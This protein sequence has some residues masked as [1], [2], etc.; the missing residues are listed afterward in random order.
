MSVIQARRVTCSL[1]LAMFCAVIALAHSPQLIGFA[2]PAP[3][4]LQAQATAHAVAAE[5][6]GL[7]EVNLRQPGLSQFASAVDQAHLVK[8]VV[9]DRPPQ[10]THRSKSFRRTA[11]RR[12]LQQ[13]D[14]ENQQQWIV[15]TEWSDTGAPP[16]VVFA[17]LPIPRTSYAAVPTPNGWLFVEI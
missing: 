10:S 11:E 15:L 6:A 1:I 5:P 17:V 14:L 8:A 13:P 16:R 3:S 7:H 2:P 12:D 4:M 9:P